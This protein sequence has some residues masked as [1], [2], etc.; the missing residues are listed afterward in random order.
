MNRAL[1]S[2][3]VKVMLPTHLRSNMLAQLP[4][5]IRRR[6]MFIAGENSADVLQRVSNAIEDV[7]SGDQSEE[8]ARTALQRLPELLDNPRLQ[9]EGRSR[10]ILETNIDLA[11]GYGNYQQS[12]DVDVLSEYPAWELY[13]AEDRKE[14]RDWPA[15]WE[16]AGGEFYPGDADYP[17][18]RMIALKDDPIWAKI[19]AFDQPYA[20]FDYNSGMDVRDIDRDEAEKLGL[21][22]ANESVQPDRISFNDDF[23][24]HPSA[25]G[26]ILGALVEYY[27]E[28]GIG[29]LV[30]KAVK[31][32]GGVL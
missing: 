15:R 26:E 28:A 3:V 5:A 25:T 32:I 20:P 2:Q 9:S 8:G 14:P 22:D 7:L 29:K 30:G 10:L 27:A 1:E 19:S 24:A 12:Q 18:G 17:E 13:R 4:A 21:I 6:S 23:Q 11:R 31:L 16:E